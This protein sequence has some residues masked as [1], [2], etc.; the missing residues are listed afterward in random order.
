MY[1]WPI[2]VWSLRVW[3]GISIDVVEATPY[4]KLFANCGRRHHS[5][6]NF[7]EWRVYS[8]GQLS[9]V[10]DDAEI[11]NQ[12]AEARDTPDCYGLSTPAQLGLADLRHLLSLGFLL[13]LLDFIGGPDVCKQLRDIDQ[14][15]QVKT[16]I[17]G[18]RSGKAFGVN[19][20][21]E[22]QTDE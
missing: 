22:S 21:L 17:Q 9:S 8:L 11:W 20:F 18:M 16:P 3:E 1:I 4:S 14:Q 7:T 2:S 10:S 12:V 15:P 13:P 5:N 6:D 19:A